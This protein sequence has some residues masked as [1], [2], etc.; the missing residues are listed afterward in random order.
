MGRRN[1]I[2][3]DLEACPIDDVEHHR[4][5]Y[6]S[7][8]LTLEKEYEVSVVERPNDKFRYTY[9]LSTVG[10]VILYILQ[11]CP[12]V[13]IMSCTRIGRRIMFNAYP[14]EPDEGGNEVAK[15]IE[16]SKSF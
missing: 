4:R 15:L 9:V 13:C 5:V 14:Y 2:I 6:A 3:H 10:D 11:E 12:A 16:K 7:L 1:S 8:C